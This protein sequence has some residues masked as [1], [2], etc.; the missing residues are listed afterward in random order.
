MEVLLA[1][2]CACFQNVREEAGAS[3]DRLPPSCTLV[4]FL[5]YL[6]GGSQT[7]GFPERNRKGEKKQA[8]LPC[9]QDR[10]EERPKASAH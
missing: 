2:Y 9:R 6:C 8:R 1:Y 4:S 7:E 3:L 5:P 10:E